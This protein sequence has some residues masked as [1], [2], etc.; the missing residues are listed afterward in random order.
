MRIISSVILSLLAS[1][2]SCRGSGA[3]PSLLDAPA[4]GPTDDAYTCAPLP[5]R[6]ADLGCTKVSDLD[7]PACAPGAA[8]ICRA[9]GEPVKCH[10]FT[11][12][13]CKECP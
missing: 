6:C 10:C 9:T 8:C 3:A 1:C 4:D 13:G 12:P 2:S 7:D 5:R 11:S